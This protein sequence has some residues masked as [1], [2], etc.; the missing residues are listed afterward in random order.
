MCSILIGSLEERQVMMFWF[1][2]WYSKQ[3][4]DYNIDA[5]LIIILGSRLFDS[6]SPA[7]ALTHSRFSTHTVRLLTKP[8]GLAS[9]CLFLAPSRMCSA[10]ARGQGHVGLFYETIHLKDRRHIDGPD[11]V[12]ALATLFMVRPI[13]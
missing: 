1:N 4:T 9:L 12:S 6:H 5:R 13:S 8:H 3:R 11:G 10:K 2:K 7:S